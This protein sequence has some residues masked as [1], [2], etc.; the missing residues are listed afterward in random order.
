MSFQKIA[1][2]GPGLLG[3][4]IALALRRKC[5]SVQIGIWARRVEAVEE[6]RSTGIAD[7][8]S[9]DLAT[10]VEKADLIVFCVPI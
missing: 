2:L 1:I 4:S 3:G 8:A 10:V 5:P 7:I 6:I 9:F